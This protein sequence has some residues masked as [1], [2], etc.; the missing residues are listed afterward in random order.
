[1]PQLEPEY[2]APQLVWLAL[3]FCALYLLMAFVLIPRVKEPIEERRDRIQ[4]D[5]DEAERLNE[6]MKA[7]LAAYEGALADAR[8]SAT[9]LA[10][11][12]RTAVSAELAKEQ[13]EVD[14]ALE[15][16]AAEAESRILSAKT[17]ALA[18]VEQIAAETA[19]TL[20]QQVAGVSVDPAE[21]AQSVR[22]VG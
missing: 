21:V 12:T 7:A 15:A 1:M 17:Q 10:A 9:S 4:R 13:A 3:T 18:S 22:Q 8:Q 16:K 19:Q 11:E 2:F 5:L 6:E 20:V 14:A